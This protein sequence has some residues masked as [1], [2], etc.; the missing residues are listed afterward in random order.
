MPKNRTLHP[1]IKLKICNLRNIAKT[2]SDTS[3]IWRF[4]GSMEWPKGPQTEKETSTYHTDHYIRVQEWQNPLLS[5]SD[6]VPF[7]WAPMEPPTPHP[8]ESQK[9]ERATEGESKHRGG[10]RETE[11]AQGSGC[12]DGGHCCSCATPSVSPQIQSSPPFVSAAPPKRQWTQSDPLTHSPEQVRERQRGR[13]WG[14]E[15]TE[16]E[17]KSE[18]SVQRERQWRKTSEQK[19]ETDGE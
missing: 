17:R 16:I 18:R 9:A 8:S 7:F 14:R 19:A 4:L 2:E 13:G 11:R 15:K 5:I 12:G 10:E 3:G 1:R 6:P